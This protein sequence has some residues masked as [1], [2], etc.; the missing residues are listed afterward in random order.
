MGQE[1]GTL[2][3]VSNLNLKFFEKLKNQVWNIFLDIEVHLFIHTYIG[4]G[5]TVAHFSKFY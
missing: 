2:E 5:H 3:N 4:S 1:S